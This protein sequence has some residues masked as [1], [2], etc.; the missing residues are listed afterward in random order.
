MTAVAQAPGRAPGDADGP[1]AGAPSASDPVAASPGLVRLDARGADPARRVRLPRGVERLAGVVLLI[2]L[3]QLASS[4]GWITRDTLA[5]PSTV[6][7]AGWDLLTS[8]VLGSAIWA[9]FQR[10]VWGLAIGVPIGLVLAVIAGLS[11]IGEDVVDSPMHALRFLPIIALQPLIVLWFGIGATAKV[12]LIVLGVVFPIYVNTSTAIRSIDPK[13]LELASTV[14][15]SRWA[16]VRRVVLP[17]ALPAF[18]VGLRMSV[19]VAW[20]ILV[21]AEQMNARDGIGY[22]MIRA[23][24]FFQTDVIVVGLAVYAVLGL[25]SDIGVRL[26][27]GRVLRWQPGR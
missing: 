18:L 19:A 16:T 7:N 26:V 5:G 11:R 12:S 8:G 15:L 27:E 1:E 10:V 20:L 24:T 25:L 4:A 3:W 21:F 14:G 2:A 17:A 6:L 9:S 22:L 23:Q 13:H